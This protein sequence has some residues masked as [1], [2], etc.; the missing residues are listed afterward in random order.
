MPVP[1]STGQSRSG[2]SAPLTPTSLW[3]AMRRASTASTTFREETNRTSY[4]ALTTGQHNSEYILLLS[5]ILPS[6][7]PPPTSPPFTPPPL[8]MHT[9]RYVK[10]W[11]YQNKACVQTLEGHAQNVTAVAFHPELPII[12]TG[13]EDGR[14]GGISL[15]SYTGISKGGRTRYTVS[16]VILGY[17]RVGGLGIL[18]PE[19]YRDIQ[20]WAD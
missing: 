14:R 18:S 8:Y 12:M 4:L 2:S 19:L 15:Q 3:R 11:D 20:G 16:K 9:H 6:L 7:H 13:S 5:F 17:P 10:I 1:P